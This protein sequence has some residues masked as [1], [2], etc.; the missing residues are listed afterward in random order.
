ALIRAIGASRRQVFALVLLEA[1]A[2]GVIASAVG[3][4]AGIAT[5]S[6]LLT[7]LGGVGMEIP[8]GDLVVSTSTL[9]TGLVTGLLVTLVAAASSARRAAR[10]APVAAMR[11]GSDD[12][13]TSLRRRSIIGGVLGV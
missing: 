7:L 4:G 12:T 3:I 11:D 13:A 6:G 2:L 1:G 9:L 8:D 5:A 10:V